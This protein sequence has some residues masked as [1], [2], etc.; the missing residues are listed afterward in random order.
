MQLS[1]IPVS[2]LALILW[3]ATA[4]VGLWEIVVVQ[5][6]FL[7]LYIRFGHDYWVGL[8]LRNWIVLVLSMVWLVFAIFTGEY[9]HKRVGQR[10][11]WKLFG[12]TAAVE[13]GILVVALFV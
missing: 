4:V 7:R 12:L 13:L 1:R 6:I 9:H 3:L 5:G 8:T 2:V 10:A 11:S